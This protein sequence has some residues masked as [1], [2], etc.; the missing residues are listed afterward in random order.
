MKLD[1]TDYGNLVE[2]STFLA[3]MFRLL[4]RYGATYVDYYCRDFPELM[5][6]FEPLAPEVLESFDTFLGECC[7]IP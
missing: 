1:S 4:G 7:E 3:L 5:W 2:L 6:K